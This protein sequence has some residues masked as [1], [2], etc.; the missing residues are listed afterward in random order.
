M[1]TRRPN[2]LDTSALEALLLDAPNAQTWG[3]LTE[4]L[5][6]RRWDR[7]AAQWLPSALAA[8]DAR[9]TD[10]DRCW[11]IAWRTKKDA[12]AATALARRLDLMP[13]TPHI[14]S[15][16]VAQLAAL[17][18]SAM[19]PLTILRALYRHTKTPHLLDSQDVQLIWDRL[20]LATL[21]HIH[22]ETPGINYSGYT[23][24]F[25][26]AMIASPA[27]R[28]V[29]TLLL[30]H[31]TADQLAR[32]AASPHLGALRDLHVSL[33][34]HTP[35]TPDT[36]RR[37]ATHLSDQLTHLALRREAYYEGP[38]H[39]A[40][41]ERPWPAL[42]DLTLDLI[43]LYDAALHDLLHAAPS[44]RSLTLRG[45]VIT[46]RGAQALHA[47]PP[48]G[49]TSLDLYAYQDDDASAAQ[50]LRAPALSNLTHLCLT[51]HDH[52][53]VGAAVGQLSRL[54]HLTLR[55]YFS[56]S[57]D[58]LLDGLRGASLPQLT[59]LTLKAQDVAALDA[60]TSL[61]APALRTVNL[62]DIRDYDRRAVIA[63][64][65]PPSCEIIIRR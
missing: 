50:L 58:Q 24:A 38:T 1:A 32:L 8:L 60:L 37:L 44:L 41:W 5:A 45:D 55:A 47:L 20:A 18:A 21:R 43:P 13:A 62:A 49:L 40:L 12:P 11:P 30:T 31:I 19:P 16:T 10:E 36:Y 46:A 54:E 28:A 53:A 3:A 25:V 14:L 52:A 9:W 48:H 29:E 7:H 63:A 57:L 65:F 22:I 39:A 17:D 33:R 35:D 26:E 27:L 59:S 6:D 34:D 42:T 56:D 4:L 61:H 51:N 2:T 15:K 64:I 23:A